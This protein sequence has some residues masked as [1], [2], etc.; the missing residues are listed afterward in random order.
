MMELRPQT[1]VKQGTRA[2]GRRGT[3]KNPPR[4]LGNSQNKNGDVLQ[5][6]G[7]KS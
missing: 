1:A 7:V 5:N 2:E 3:R 4:S 6:D